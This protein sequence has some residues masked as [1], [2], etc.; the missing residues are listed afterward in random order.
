[1]KEYILED[2]F[3]EE[4]CESSN[5]E[6]IDLLFHTPITSNLREGEKKKKFWRKKII[7]DE[8]YLNSYQRR[9]CC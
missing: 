1:M 7:F 2:S 6:E 5:D 3:E 8:I 4:D 9:R